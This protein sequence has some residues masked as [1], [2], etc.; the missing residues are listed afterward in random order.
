MTAA[1]PG[2]AKIESAMMRRS[3][4]GMLAPETNANGGSRR[5]EAL[6]RKYRRRT[7]AHAAMPRKTEKSVLPTL[8]AQPS[9]RSIS[10]D[11]VGDREAS[12]FCY[13]A[14]YTNVL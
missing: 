6:S 10:S 7:Q 14:R 13:N 8:Q 9:P 3:D 12:M 1:R 2:H 5:G 11:M 4:L